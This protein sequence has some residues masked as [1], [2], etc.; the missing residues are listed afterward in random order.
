MFD[1][2]KITHLCPHKLKRTKPISVVIMGWLKCLTL[3]LAASCLND[4]VIA[5]SDTDMKDPS[6]PP[7]DDDMLDA[8]PPPPARK[9]MSWP[10]PPFVWDPVHQSC[11]GMGAKYGYE[12][13]E[14][15]Q[16]AILDEVILLADNALTKMKQLE[17][18]IDKAK[19]DFHLHQTWHTY[20]EFFNIGLEDTQD[21]WDSVKCKSRA[22]LMVLDM[23]E[24]T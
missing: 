6:L 5:Q 24:L 21:R 4:V 17:G 15:A 7:S 22:S 11:Q 8:S 23:I 1:P 12:S 3:G 9:P 16:E 10:D 18:N 19:T 13:D 20:D 14:K 2:P